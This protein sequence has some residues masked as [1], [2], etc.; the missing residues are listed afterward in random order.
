VTG[1]DLRRD[2]APAAARRCVVHGRDRTAVPQHLTG[3]RLCGALRRRR[4]RPYDLT[5]CLVAE[6][7][8]VGAMT[9]AVGRGKG[10]RRDGER[11]ERRRLTVTRRLAREHA[12]DIGVH[13]QGDDRVAAAGPRHSYAHRRWG[14]LKSAWRRAHEYER[15]HEEK[16]NHEDSKTRRTFCTNRSSSCFRAFV[17]AFAFVSTFRHSCNS[18]KSATPSQMRGRLAIS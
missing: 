17:V 11:L 4:R 1:P 18:R 3:C 6:I 10:T 8:S 2:L 16:C 14:I 5:V 12:R 15:D 13:R 9:A 7:E